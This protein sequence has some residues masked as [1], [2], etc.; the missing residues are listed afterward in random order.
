MP[1]ASPGG[2]LLALYEYSWNN[3]KDP[4]YQPFGQRVPPGDGKS[5]HLLRLLDVGTGL[6]A[7]WQLRA[8]ARELRWAP[9][10]RTLAVAYDDGAI[11]LC[12]MPPRW[13]P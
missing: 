2:R 1:A 7:R 8:Q 4:P 6:Q 12:D 10:G 9:D 11:H 13:G 5:F 3:P